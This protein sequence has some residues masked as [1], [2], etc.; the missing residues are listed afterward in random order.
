MFLTTPRIPTYIVA[1]IVGD[2]EYTEAI[3]G[4]LRQRVY[5]RSSKRYDHFFSLIN[6]IL[7]VNYFEEYC[8]VD[9]MAPKLD[10][11]AL[12]ELKNH[13]MENWGLATYTESILLYNKTT[14]KISSQ[15]TT[16]KI[17]AHE[18][19]HLWFG[20]YVTIQWWNNLWLKEGFATL[21]SY[22]AIEHVTYKN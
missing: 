9:Y 1:F 17:L 5:S 14:S 10:H 12:M 22:K 6:A 8:G 19:A 4:G 3:Y 21:F 13:G 7:F 11:V 2:F 16:A 20:D 15:T 18:I